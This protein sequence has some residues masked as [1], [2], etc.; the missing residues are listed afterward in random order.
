VI[1]ALLLVFFVGLAIGFIYTM[2][3]GRAV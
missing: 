2:H 1:Y 3:K